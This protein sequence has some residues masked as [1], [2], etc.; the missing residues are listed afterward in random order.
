MEDNQF[1][2]RMSIIWGAVIVLVL[3]GLLIFGYVAND[4]RGHDGR[5]ACDTT[6]N[7]GY[8]VTI[9]CTIGPRQ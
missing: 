1:A 6:G 7:N 4:P 5:M 8:S 2:I 3:A 9:V